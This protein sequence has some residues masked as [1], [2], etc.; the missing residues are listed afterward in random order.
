MR[1]WRTLMW[2]PL[3]PVR[4]PGSVPDLVKS[5]SGGLNYAAPGKEW[6]W[7]NH[8]PAQAHPQQ[9]VPYRSSPLI[10]LCRISAL[11]VSEKH[12]YLLLHDIQTLPVPE[13]APWFSSLLPVFLP[14]AGTRYLERRN[15]ARG[16]SPVRFPG[17]PQMLL[18]EQAWWGLPSHPPGAPQP[19]GTCPAQPG[20]K[21]FQLQS[22]VLCFP[23]S[24]CESWLRKMRSVRAIAFK[25]RSCSFLNC[26][27]LELTIPGSIPHSGISNGEK[28]R[29]SAVVRLNCRFPGDQRQRNRQEEK[30]IYV[31]PKTLHRFSSV[32]CLQNVCQEKNLAL[33]RMKPHTCIVRVT[34]VTYKCHQCFHFIH[35]WGD[36][37]GDHMSAN[38]IIYVNWDGLVRKLQLIYINQGFREQ[39]PP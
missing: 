26:S 17:F 22:P 9:A 23:V 15:W 2:V 24:C 10:S 13:P 8:W 34:M 6:D 28:T 36:S 31:L 7:E 11:R 5:V 21:L 37:C 35:K 14:V 19:L 1:F 16:C 39:P 12:R 25:A 32:L 20:E 27:W 33:G 18:P 4:R 29:K 30:R 3:K 38:G